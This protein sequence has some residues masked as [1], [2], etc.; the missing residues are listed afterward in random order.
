[1]NELSMYREPTMTIQEVAETLGYEQDTIRKKVKELFPEIV[2]NGIQTRLKEIHVHEIKKNLAPRTLALKS[3]VE[4]AT[5]S[6]DIE[7][8][9]VKVLQYHMAEAERL[10]IENERQRE[11]LAI[12]APK[13]DFYNAVT[14][15]KDT[16][17]IG[18]AAKVMAIKGIGRNK[19]FEL[20]RDKGILMQNNQPYQKYI[21]AGYFR[22]IESSYTTPDGMTHVNIKT[23]VYQR[24][25]DYI[26]KVVTNG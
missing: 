12:E 22:T 15:S 19:L 20:L 23:V 1:M 6:L 4:N 3:E 25:L 10:R 24:G 11:Q 5:T 14:G 17:D 26:R 9:T 2:K 8:M 16:I 7:E 13:V 18:E 21:D